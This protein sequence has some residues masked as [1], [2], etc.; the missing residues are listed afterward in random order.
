M[1]R[2]QTGVLG[3]CSSYLGGFFVTD[4]KMESTD[5]IISLAWFF[6]KSYVSIISLGGVRLVAAIRLGEEMS[7]ICSL[8][9]SS[10]AQRT[11]N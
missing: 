5:S 10:T 2:T 3:I 6:K 9:I 1:V 7:R 8:S 11:D 4:F